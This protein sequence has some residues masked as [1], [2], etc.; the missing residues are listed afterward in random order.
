[1][2][3]QYGIKIV[4]N[5]YKS[6]IVMGKQEYQAHD[7]RVE[8]DFSQAAFYLVA[9]AIGNDV[10]LTDLNLDSLQGDKATLEFLEAWG[11]KFL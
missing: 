9:G 10:V 7:Y 1:M 8:A 5:D 4:N 3:N 11:L 6:F 2:L